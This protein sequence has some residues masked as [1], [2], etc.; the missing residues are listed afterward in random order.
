[1]STAVKRIAGGLLL[2]GLLTGAFEL[3]TRRPLDVPVPDIDV[4][5][6]VRRLVLVSHGSAD[7]DN[8]LFP[9]IV[10]RIERHFADAD[11]VAVRYL[12]WAPWSDQRLRAVATAER[13]GRGLGARLGGL[14][15]LENLQL[16]VHSS[17]AYIADA[18][19]ESYR[20]SLT[21]ARGP[22]RVTMVF[23]D[24]FQLRGVLDWRHGARRHGHCAD[25]AL[26]I[27][28]TDDPAPASNV[29]LRLAWNIDVTAHAGKQTF[30]RNGHY[31]PLQY[32]LDYLPGLVGEPREPDHARFPRGG[33]VTDPR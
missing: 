29:P 1:M 15:A 7:G 5:A 23:L 27:L 28:N 6:D 32:Y 30:P 19:C 18:L 31:W 9:K 14:T 17:G 21:S 4:P 24:P 11:A 26:A 22:A 13:L 10:A 25:F 16:V 20:A 8:P 33:I 2:I 3:Y 12:R